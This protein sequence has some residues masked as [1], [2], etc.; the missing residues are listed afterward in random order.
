MKVP[1]EAVKVIMKAVRVYNTVTAS[2][3]LSQSWEN[4]SE[5]LLQAKKV[6]IDCRGLESV[7]EAVWVSVETVRVSIEALRCFIGCESLEEVPGNVNWG[8]ESLESASRGCKKTLGK[9]VTKILEHIKTFWFCFKFLRLNG[10]VPLLFYK[11]WNTS[12]CFGF[13]SKFLD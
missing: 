2:A 7:L 9:T 6:F 10:K 12:K 5:C 11:F 3:T 8:R 13:V 4:F 1:V